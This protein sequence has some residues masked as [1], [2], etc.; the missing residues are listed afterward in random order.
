MFLPGSSCGC[1]G[2]SCG[3]QGGSLPDKVTVSFSGLVGGRYRGPNVISLSMSNC[4]A[5][6]ATGTVV[7]PGGDNFGPIT[8][9]LVTSNRIF[10]KRGRRAPTLT[11]TGA[12]SGATF[13]PSYSISTDS[14]GLQT[15]A[16]QSVS[17]SG[18]T[19]YTYGEWLTIAESVGDTVERYAG[20]Q[21]ATN[22]VAPT[23]TA[24]AAGGTGAAL[25][26]TIAPNGTTPQSWS[27][28]SVSVQA[29][30]SGYPGQGQLSIEAAAGDTTSEAAY[31]EFS[32]GRLQPSITLSVNGS[33]SGAELSASLEQFTDYDGSTWW[34][35]SGISIVNGGAGYSPEDWIDAS[36]DGQGCCLYAVVTS[37]DNDGAITGVAIYYGGSY[38]KSDGVIQSVTVYSGGSYYR[39]TGVP[40]GVSIAD[41]GAY[42]R[43]D[44]SLPPIAPPVTVTINTDAYNG[45]GAVITATLQLNT[46]SVFFGTISSLSV[47]N[48]GMHYT[49]WRWK[50]SA[51]CVERFN[52]KSFTLPRSTLI[53]C[54]YSKTTCENEYQGSKDLI[55]VAYGGP[56]EPPNV[57][58]GVPSPKA[59]V[60][61]TA[62]S[63]PS[64]SDFSFTATDPLGGTATV[65]PGGDAPEMPCGGCCIGGGTVTFCSGDAKWVCGPPG[66]SACEEAP[67][68]DCVVP[69]QNK[70]RLNCTPEQCQANGGTWHDICPPPQGATFT[71]VVVRCRSISAGGFF[72]EEL[73]CK[74]VDTFAKLTTE[75][76]ACEAMT[77]TYGPGTP[78]VLSLL[79]A[80]PGCQG[81]P[82]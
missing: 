18:G 33:G 67:N 38:Y 21:V 53:A 56:N 7:A 20:V 30:G 16:I 10:A 31:A 17:V 26:V 66:S 62:T 48:G 75:K 58:I 37:V 46:A 43:E 45:S 78:T 63:T 8:S 29:G 72:V 35:V 61:F 15:W 40:T 19:G 57:T 77:G 2:D 41:G 64:C 14:C 3:C 11:I 65:S 60:V 32:C 69:P 4:L 76:S 52:G 28:T 71:P 47:V 70:P 5:S 22:I 73:F 23:V 12:G 80:P 36:T 51:F 9:A 59:E 27:V 82:P 13:T 39:D 42:Y 44:N 79:D 49:L 1:C 81:M 54:G 34:R 25:S 55:L 6:G 50:Q 74:Y 24:S 68:G